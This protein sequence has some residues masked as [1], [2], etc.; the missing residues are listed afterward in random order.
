MCAHYGRRGYREKVTQDEKRASI[1][2]EKNAL[3]KRI[4]ALNDQ[5]KAL[6]DAGECSETGRLPREK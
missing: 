5:M 2:G 3:Q 1:E 6:D 4:E